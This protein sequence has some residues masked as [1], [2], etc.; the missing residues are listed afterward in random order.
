MKLRMFD[1][2]FETVTLAQ[3]TEQILALVGEG[4]RELIVTPNVDHIVSMV[5]DPHMREVFE[6]A[7]HRY[8]DGMPLV[9]LS[10]LRFQLGLP[11]RVTGADLLFSLSEGGAR[12]GASIYLLG[13]MPGVAETAAAKLMALHPGLVVAGVHSPPLGFEKDEV[14]SRR[15]VDLVNAA[16]PNVLF[17]GVGTPKQ[18]KWAHHWRE[19]LRCDV[20]LGVG[21]AIDFAAGTARRAPLIVQRSGFEWLWRAL[22]NPRRLGPRYIK[23]RKFFALALRELGRGM[24]QQPPR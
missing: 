7:R 1:L 19:H 9:W 2:D 11:D 12:R 15:I 18:E 8:A 3:A 21:A 22:G 13:A 17:I 10:R 16:R 20:I 24:R 4:R 6:Q 5:H 14:E 23:D